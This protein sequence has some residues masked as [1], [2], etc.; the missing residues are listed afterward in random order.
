MSLEGSVL[1]IL[2]G[3]SITAVG[4]P[5]AAYTVVILIMI[6]LIK[7][8]TARSKQ[9][10]HSKD[11]YVSSFFKQSTEAQDKHTTAMNNLTAELRNITAELREISVKVNTYA[12][13][14]DKQIDMQVKQQTD[15]YRK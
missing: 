4:F 7:D 15:K 14:I 2:S 3:E 11:E 6:F 8:C 12:K 1:S 9:C 10:Q 5:I 13:I